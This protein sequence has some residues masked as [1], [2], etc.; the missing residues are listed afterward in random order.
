MKK[1]YL[2][3]IALAVGGTVAAQS[4]FDFESVNIPQESYDNGGPTQGGGD[5]V[6]T[7]AESIRLTN[8]YDTSFGGYWSGFAISNTTNTTTQSF[9][10]QYSSVTG[11]GAGGSANYAVHYTPGTISAESANTQITEF[12][13]TNTA[14]T[15]L[16]M[17]NGNSLAKVFGSPNGANGMPDG[18]NG[19]DYFKVWIVASSEA[20]DLDSMEFFLADYR[21]SDDAQDYIVDSWETID[22]V[23]EFSFPVSELNFIFK[24]SDVN[25]AGY[26]NTPTYFAIDD[27]KTMGAVGLTTNELLD[28]HVY[29]NPVKDIL[30]VNAPEGTL[31]VVD[32]QGNVVFSGKHNQQTKMDVSNFASGVYVIRWHNA[33]D[34]YTNRVIVQ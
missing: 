13:I 28:I 15:K 10:N 31:E 16:V 8:V 18:T 22:L 11:S 33:S 9:L 24:S 19:E 26:I 1:I 21:F 6:F 23:Q 3:I 2:S 30:T 34:S 32:M 12:K 20:G 7:E 14:W 17:E 4:T 29:P 25:G 27:I 5:F